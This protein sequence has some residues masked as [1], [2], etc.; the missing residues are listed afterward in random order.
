MNNDGILVMMV[1]FL[2]GMI[3]IVK[4]IVNLNANI[5]KL[6]TILEDFRNDYEKSHKALENRVTNHGQQIDNLDK[7][8]A[9]HEVRINNIEKEV[10]KK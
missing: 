2:V 6:T 10:N 3:A 9:T 5:T 8:V 4:P 1:S 7:T